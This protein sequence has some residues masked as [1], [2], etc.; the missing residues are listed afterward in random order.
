[1]GN[2]PEA[3]HVVNIWVV[4]RNHHLPHAVSPVASICQ[5]CAVGFVWTDDVAIGS[6]I[7]IGN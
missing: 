6:R 7:G 1:M 2:V 3:I 5:V 4:R